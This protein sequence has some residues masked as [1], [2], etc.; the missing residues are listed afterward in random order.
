MTI[1]DVTVSI[2]VKQAT[3]VVGF[4]IPAVFVPVTSGT[5]NTY[6]EYTSLEA[7]QID[8]LAGTSTLSFA[9]SFFAQQGHPKS[10]AVIKYANLT[11]AYNLFK[12]KG[13]YI[14]VLAKEGI[15]APRPQSDPKILELSNLIESDQYR[16]L[17]VLDTY[18]STEKITDEATLL[19]V[20]DGNTRT[21]IMVSKASQNGRMDA[22]LIGAFGARTIGSLNWHDLSAP[23]LAADDWDA[24]SLSVIDQSGVMAYVNKSNN[25][26][27]T[28]S[29]KTVSGMY[30]DQIMGIDWVA[31]QIQ[32]RLQDV[33]TNNDKVGY[34]TSGIALLQSV[35][36]NV[37]GQA[38]SN[39]IVDVDDA[40]G[41]PLYTVTALS[42][43]EI[44]KSDII[45]RVY[46]GLSYSYTP[47]GAVDLINVQ[48]SINL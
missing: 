22:A 37:L 46:N 11:D 15:T 6:H 25:I 16:I 10:M 44:D 26:A 43:S 9:E 30:I 8:F 14:A 18:G 48:G 38:Y 1:T 41:N 39:G 47:A 36:E 13:W 5:T 24:V 33:L 35:V 34:D 19:G 40:S 4:G 3:S 17:F 42:R 2:A 23:G 7:V 32:T 27:Q 20:I 28:T 21:V 29:G 12:N 31:Q 45:G